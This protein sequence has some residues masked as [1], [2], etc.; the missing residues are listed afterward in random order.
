MLSGT[1]GENRVGGEEWTGGPPEM[2]KHEL[3][4]KVRCPTEEVNS[5]NP[6]VQGE[7]VT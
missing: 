1:A 3:E 2:E 7:I 6:Q 5:P 4:Q